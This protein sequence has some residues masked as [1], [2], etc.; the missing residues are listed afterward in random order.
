MSRG[1]TGRGGVNV[2]L[3]SKGEVAHL[4]KLQNIDLVLPNFFLLINKAQQHCSTFFFFLLH[5]L[6]KIHFSG[7]S[8]SNLDVICPQPRLRHFHLPRD[9]LP[10]VSFDL[11]W[12][13]ITE[14]SVCF[15]CISPSWQNMHCFESIERILLWSVAL[16][17][18]VKNQAIFLIYLSYPILNLHSSSCAS[19]IP[20]KCL[21]QLHSISCQSFL[22][23]Q[24]LSMT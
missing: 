15:L 2:L 18:K 10:Q 7:I 6:T 16:A 22:C 1:K 21:T 9:L 13:Y 3:S 4:L 20:L 5:F 19:V 17:E 14:H 24:C 11:F 8:Y 23:L 12:K